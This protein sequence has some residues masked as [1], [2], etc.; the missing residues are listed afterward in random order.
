MCTSKQNGMHCKENDG[1]KS[2]RGGDLLISGEGMMA[3]IAYRGLL[4]VTICKCLKF[5]AG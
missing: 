2:P 1:I 5:G 3:V 4:Y